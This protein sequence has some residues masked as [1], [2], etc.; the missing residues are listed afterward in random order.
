MKINSK[1]VLLIS[2]MLSSWLFISGCSNTLEAPSGKIILLKGAIAREENGNHTNY[3]LT[4]GKYN[5]L[6]VDKSVAA[7]DIISGNYIYE[8]E[9]SA[10]IH[11]KDEDMKIL[12]KNIINPKLSS[13]GDYYSYF[14]KDKYMQ[15]VVKSLKDNKEIE[16]N[17]NVA[18][19]GNLM[20][21]SNNNIIYYGID[22]N[23]TNGIFSYNISNG[24]EELIYK[25]ESGYLEFLKASKDGIVFLQGSLSGKKILKSIDKEKKIKVITDEIVELKDIEISE[26][27]IFILGKMKDN[28]HSIYEVKD[29][30][31]NRIIY[32]FPNIVHLEKGLSSDENGNVLFIGSTDSFE[33]EKIYIYEDGYVKVLTNDNFK[34]YFV[35]IK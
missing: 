35:D 4:E 18:I 27:G 17:T 1:Y 33:K 12:D 11:Y 21:W 19:S 6:E 23:K 3:N 7:Y 14:K 32:D 5:K 20:D 26:K 25:L 8:K 30:K 16:I 13:G 22:E 29:G 2:S 10:F 34:Y 31:V 9:G 24:K 15:L 28:N